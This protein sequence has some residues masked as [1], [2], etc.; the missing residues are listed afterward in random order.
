MRLKSLMCEVEAAGQRVTLECILGRAQ[1]L[2][3]SDF[4]AFTT[5]ISQVDLS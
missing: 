2:F 4:I 3:L 5:S 1:W